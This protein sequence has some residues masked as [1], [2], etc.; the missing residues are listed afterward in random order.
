MEEAV[1]EPLEIGVSPEV[2]D[3]G[4]AEERATFGLF[5]I[6]ADS[7]SLSEGFD[8]YLKGYRQG[9]LISGYYAAEWFAWNWWRLRWEPRSSS[10]EWQ[11]A[12]DM[13]S[14]GEGYVWPTITIF[15]DGLR[16]ALISRPSARRDAKPF[17]YAG[18][19]STVVESVTFESALDDFVGSTLGRLQERGVSQTNL[20][21]LWSDVL[22]ERADANL[23][24]YRR[25]EALLGRDPD[26]V[27]DGSVTRLLEDA[28]KLGEQVLQE[29]AAE[30]GRGGEVLSAAVFEQL[31]LD[32][33]FDAAPQ[34]LV[35]L[36][37]VFGVHLTADEPAWRVGARAADALRE[38]AGLGVEP[39][40]NPGL[41]EMA[42]TKV[43]T[44]LDQPTG[45]PPVSF[46]LD[47]NQGAGATRV[48][49]RSKWATGRRFDLARLMGDKLIVGA[50]ALSPATRAHTYRQKAQRSFAAELLSPFDAVE[51]M[52]AGDYSLESQ[53][54][55]ADYF[56]VSP[57]TINTL[58]MNHGRIEREPYDLD[59]EASAA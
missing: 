9:P 52:L 2:L 14:I 27:E 38:Y 20:E 32:Q 35:N 24:R 25:F 11:M 29:V 39:I 4:S 48:V 1:V 7:A 34:N 12:H 40:S 43:T 36:G 58:L 44:I 13:A 16:T 26:A 8:S 53:Q 17:R 10:A 15:S 47:E 19:F 23:A 51:K 5:V 49:L 30:A 56:D 22:G 6:R 54:D 37:P 50:S 21:R 28:G 57:M 31:A 45:R 55:V 46:I 59:F 33:G 41:A 3:E 42:G 18:S